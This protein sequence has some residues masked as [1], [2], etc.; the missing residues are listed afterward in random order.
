[1]TTLLATLILA[2]PTASPPPLEVKVDG[3]GYLRF[4]RAGKV[5]F[6]KTATLTV[7]EGLLASRDGL[8]VAPSVPIASD[9]RQLEIDLE[10]HVTVVRAAGKARAG[11]LVL[12]TFPA[13]TTL[14][15][16]AGYL[17]AGLRATLGNPGEGLNGVVRT[18]GASSS[19]PAPAPAAS[20]GEVF[21]RVAVRSEVDGDLIFLRDVAQISGPD[22]TVARLGAVD[23]GR[24]PVHGL[25][26][27]LSQSYLLTRLRGAGFDP[28][29][30]RLEVP[31]AAIVSRS[32]ATISAE[33]LLAAA[34]AAAQAHH[35]VDIAF[36]SIRPITVMRVPPGDVDV[37]AEQVR[38]DGSNTVVVLAVTVDGRR[39]GTR[40]LT[41][42]PQAGAASVKA[43]DPV[44][45]RLV[46]N[47]LTVE[48]PGTARGAA[49]V[50][51]AVPV[52]TGTGTT[53][54]GTLVAPGLV[55]VK[56]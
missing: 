19:A 56:L 37:A 5:V 20:P 17:T 11:R 39:V 36:R 3:D 27:T 22:E 30:L 33:E 12:A 4:A 16:D 13:G 48:V 35:G 7:R 24:A 10:G 1:M 38:K 9:A 54:S 28:K 45:L 44:T 32:S 25:E 40:N 41:L 52:E 43:G 23:L 47:G 21:V 29:Q 14:S 34:E 49:F 26:R 42:T 6:A 18:T 15:P 55:E 53:H 50:G 51:Q 31:S 8:P 46:R 2:S